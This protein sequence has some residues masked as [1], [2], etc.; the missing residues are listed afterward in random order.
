M[1]RV[2]I[3]TDQL[4]PELNYQFAKSGGP[5][6]QHVNKT[7]T[8]VSLS[9][10]VLASGIISPEIKE[11]LSKKLRLTKEGDLI[12]YSQGSR[13]QLQNKQEALEK[14]LFI[15]NQALYIPKKRRPTKRTKG[16]I[17]RRLTSKKHL[18]DK[19]ANRKKPI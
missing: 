3:S 13:S 8:K 14:L 5:G 11:R 12:V 1:S 2:N 4:T 9:W 15:I 16:S 17:Q 7:N 18:S 19:K 6:G 10:N